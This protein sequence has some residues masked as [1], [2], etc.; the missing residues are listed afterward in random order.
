MKVNYVHDE[1][2]DW[3]GLYIDGE[4]IDENH[5]LYV[6]HVLEALESRGLIEY[7]GFEV[8][9][10]WMLDNGRLPEEFSEIPESMLE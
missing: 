5:S 8:N 3:A 7:E 9:G 2:G 4:L 6:G 10:D 1:G